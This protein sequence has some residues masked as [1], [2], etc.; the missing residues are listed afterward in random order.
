MKCTRCGSEHEYEGEALCDDCDEEEF[1]AWWSALSEDARWE[2]L[3]K[4]MEG[5]RAD[6]EEAVHRTKVITYTMLEQAK[7]G[8]PII[9]PPKIWG[10]A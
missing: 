9:R 7:A 1:A 4:L 2:A 6:A 8:L 10:K 3:A 5:R